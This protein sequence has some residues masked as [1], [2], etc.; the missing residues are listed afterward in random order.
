M[1]DQVRQIKAYYS[2]Y[3]GY[4][5][6]VFGELSEYNGGPWAAKIYGEGGLLVDAIY[7]NK[8]K[9]E[10]HHRALLSVKEEIRKGKY[11]DRTV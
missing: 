10:A 8:T 2:K 7:G 3:D 4:N 6:E 5:L 1:H 11:V 9:A